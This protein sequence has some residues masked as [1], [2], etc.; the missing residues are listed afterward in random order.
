M[1]HTPSARSWL[2]FLREDAGA[3]RQILTFLL[4]AALLV[5]FELA[6]FV[7]IVVPQVQGPL[8]GLLA[9]LRRALGLP[10]RAVDGNVLH[11]IGA[12]GLGLLYEREEGHVQSNNATVVAH[13]TLIVGLAAVLALALVLASPGLRRQGGRAHLHVVGDVLV[14]FACLAAFQYVFWAGPVGPGP[15]PS[16]PGGTGLDWSGGTPGPSSTWRTWGRRTTRTARPPGM[17]L[18]TGPSSSSRT[19]TRWRGWRR[20]SWTSCPSR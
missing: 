13:G 10:A 7:R 9:E 1:A 18:P 2:S 19:P 3:H 5:A 4:V 15:G 11:R 6:F 16:G 8:G 20:R 14:T 12:V 17:S